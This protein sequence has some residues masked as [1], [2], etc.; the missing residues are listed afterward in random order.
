MHHVDLALPDIPV[1]DFTDRRVTVMGL[2]RFGGGVAAVQ[3]LLDRGAKVTVTDAL[4]ADEL[5][6]SLSKIDVE[7]LAGLHLGGHD[8]ADVLSADLLI[9]NP[10][11]RRDHP[12]LQLARETGVAMSS[13][14]NLFWQLRRGPV[15]GVTGSNG[16]STTAGLIHSVLK[17]GGLTTYL[18]GNIGGSLLPSLDVM[19]PDD[20]AVLELSS[21]QLHDLDRLPSS[22]EIAVVTNFTPNH[23][24]WH[25]CVDDYRRCK[26]AILGWQPPDGICVLNA[27]DPEV[28]GWCHH[29]WCYFFGETDNSA[30]GVFLKDDTILMRDKSGEETTAPVWDNLQIAGRHN[31]QNALAAAAVGLALDISPDAIA[32]GL[33][34]FEPLPHRLQ[35]V[36]EW[37]GRRFYNDSVATTPES[38]IAALESF[39][40]P[41]NLLV[42]GYDKGIDLTPLGR[43]IARSTRTAAL[44]GETADVLSLVIESDES[45]TTRAEEF[46]DLESAFAWS[47]EQSSPGDVILLSPGCASYGWFR[48]FVERGDRFCALVDN[49]VNKK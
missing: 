8:P 24:D 6:E 23:L 33:A 35:F 9:V 44:M 21:F 15:V 48:N 49:L 25:G 29:G 1:T 43:L 37:Q 42:G 30:P 10:A 41:V 20:W 2:G 14:M 7:S 17:A 39:S 26:Q 3:F 16:K 36:G 34:S 28:S 40:E 31:L 18:G 47:V 32:R 22:P 4:P 45:A 38:V 12:L 19:T 13:E 46:D 27:D 11:V 5:Q